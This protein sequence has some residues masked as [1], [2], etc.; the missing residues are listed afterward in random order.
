MTLRY[1]AFA[2]LLVVSSSIPAADDD[3]IDV[4]SQV[5]PDQHGVKG[6][7]RAA[8]KSLETNAD[9]ASRIVLPYRPGSEYDLEVAFTRKSGEHSIALMFSAGRGRAA[10]EVDGWGE[11]LSG[12][13]RIGGKT[14]KENPTRRPNM[15][16]EN[17]RRYTMTVQVR[18]DRI[19]GLLNGREIASHRSDGSDL[20]M[21]PVWQLPEGSHLGIGAYQAATTF[22]SIRVRNVSG[23]GETVAST[24]RPT[25]PA[26]TRPGT[27]RPT[28]PAP[29]RPSTTPTRPSR[30][31]TTP[32]RPASNSAR[33]LLVIANQDFFYRE[34][35]DPRAELEKAGI[36]V[37]VAAARKSACRPHGGSGQ[38]R[39][40]GVVQPDF[41]LSQVDPSRYDAIVFPGGW[42]ASTYQYAFPGRYSNAGYNSD[43]ATKEAA[44]G[45]INEFNKQDK[46]IG[47]LCHGVSVLA[48]S[49]VNERSL[50][51]GKRVTAASRSAPAGRYP[52]NLRG[53]PQS[54]WNAIQNG[55]R[56]AS[57]GSVGN[58]RTASDDVVVDGRIITAQDDSSARAF[59]RELA[60]ML[61]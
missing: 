56:V 32:T 31:S 3:W 47:A 33:V 50:I 59:G 18:K 61:K 8:G 36:T 28:R 1:S 38:G 30:P 12:I 27:T 17:G 55:A 57:P 4:L 13:Q 22:H 19:T 39:D 14:I 23:R 25:R 45:L 40:G 16:L 6:S 7:W 9:G 37:E 41:A 44:N 20:T 5:K 26:P 21:E 43:R 10:F 11:H 51:S 24:S 29:T 42:G 15:T 54:R 52:G 46:I 58:P 53:T 48:W 34:Y 49:R 35:A 2:A 60:K